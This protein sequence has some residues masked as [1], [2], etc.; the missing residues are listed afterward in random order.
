MVFNK[1]K[2]GI[3][4]GV[5]DCAERRICSGGS[6]CTGY[7]SFGDFGR[8]QKARKEGSCCLGSLCFEKRNEEVMVKEA[9]E[10]KEGEE[11]SETCNDF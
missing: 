10:A 5:R 1:E 9:K 4:R 3:K 6:G 11:V 2:S 8:N 7:K